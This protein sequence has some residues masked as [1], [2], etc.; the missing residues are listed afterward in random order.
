MKAVGMRQIDEASWTADDEARGQVAILIG[1]EG[2]LAGLW[3]SGGVRWDPFDVHLTQNGTIYV[4]SG[5][6]QLKVDDRPPVHLSPGVTTTIPAGSV[7]CWT[8][9]EDFTEVWIYH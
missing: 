8:V 3:R 1:K 9:D 6:G 5:S 4:L 7:T 2:L